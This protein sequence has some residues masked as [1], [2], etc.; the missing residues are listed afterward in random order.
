VI[1]GYLVM[2]AAATATVFLVRTRSK[3]LVAGSPPSQP[4]QGG[5]GGSR[6]WRLHLLIAL[7]AIIVL[8]NILAKLF[9]R[10]HLPPVIGQVVAGILVGPSLFGPSSPSWLISESTTCVVT[11]FGLV[12]GSFLG[13]ERSVARCYVNGRAGEMAQI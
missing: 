3:A 9:A 5:L 12:R 1:A 11:S 6:D 2:V 13:T 7:V 4:S 8:G 10:V